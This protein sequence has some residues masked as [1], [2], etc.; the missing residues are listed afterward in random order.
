LDSHWLTRWLTLGANVAV[1]AGIVLLIVELSQN[2]EQT[3]AQT[4]HEL[5][6]GIVD[7]LQEPAANPQLADVL[8][9]AKAGQPLTPT[10]QFQ[11]ELRTNA[12]FRYWEDVHYQ[13]RLGLYDDVEFTK[14]RDAWRA[15]IAS[16]ALAQTYWCT[17][18]LLYSPEFMAAMDGLLDTPCGSASVGMDSAAIRELAGRYT[19]A[20]NSGQPERVAAFFAEDATLSVNGSPASGRAAI[21]EVARGFMTAFPDLELLLDRLEFVGDHVRYHW[22]FIGSNSGPGG[23]GQRV[24]FSGYEEWTLADDGRIANSDGHFDAEEYQRQLEQG[25][26][27]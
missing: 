15:S 25:A 20:W 12:L 11:F 9:R 19:A 14:Q 18:R 22:T 24:R 13:Y 26:G 10:E 21:T 4:R 27:R 5:A 16:S 1:L 7:L 17:V 2:R 23:T 6:M 3:R 8:F